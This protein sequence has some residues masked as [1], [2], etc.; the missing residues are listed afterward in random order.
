MQSSPE[1]RWRWEANDLSASDAF[2]LSGGRDIPAPLGCQSLDLGPGVTAEEYQLL[3]PLA[4]LRWAG[5]ALLSWDDKAKSAKRWSAVS[6]LWSADRFVSR[7]QFNAL[8]PAGVESLRNGTGY[9]GLIAVLLLGPL[10]DELS[11]DER[12]VLAPF[13]PLR[14]TGSF[15]LSWNAVAFCAMRWSGISQEW[16]RDGATRAFFDSCRCATRLELVEQTGDPG[17]VFTLLRRARVRASAY[18]RASVEERKVMLHDRGTPG[19]PIPPFLPGRSRD[20]GGYFFASCCQPASA[21]AAALAIA[22]LE[23]AEVY[24]DKPVFQENV[25]DPYICPNGH[26]LQVFETPEDGWTCSVCTGSFAAGSLLHQCRLCN[27]D[28][29]GKCA[30][31][32]LQMRSRPVNAPVL[33]PDQQESRPSWPSVLDLPA[34]PDELPDEVPFEGAGRAWPSIHAAVSRSQDVHP[35]GQISSPSGW[36]CSQPR[37]WTTVSPLPFR[38]AQKLQEEDWSQFDPNSMDELGT[39]TA[40]KY[41]PD[42]FGPIDE[43]DETYDMGSL[44]EL[45]PS[46]EPQKSGLA[47]WFQLWPPRLFT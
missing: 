1:A 42:D 5:D 47:S 22:D 4:P 38:G 8:P 18:D 34:V 11:S 21:G 29:C 7:V 44:D 2:M 37:N 16:R 10:R 43:F 40:T 33:G 3:A 41:S 17:I 14:M 31:R 46:A 27:F 15:L 12:V 32:M 28:S 19:N 24:L 45:G 9:P 30:Q 6:M 13:A 39:L 23:S 35:P 20:Q 26:L 36:T 25:L